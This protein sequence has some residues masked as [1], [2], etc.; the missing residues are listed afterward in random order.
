MST[1]GPARPMTF[2]AGLVPDPLPPLPDG[3]P[4]AGLPEGLA[5]NGNALE[6]RADPIQRVLVAAGEV[7]E[8]EW[9]LDQVLDAAATSDEE[10]GL[11]LD[12]APMDGALESARWA[13]DQAVAAL[14]AQLRAAADAGVPLT[15]L[16]D[17]S[18]LQIS[19]LRTALN[20]ASDT[21]ADTTTEALPAGQLRP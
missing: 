5:G 9:A 4:A 20:A 1:P 3:P 6:R 7:E 8:A 15:D 21:A 18:G 2:P 19:A 17:A 12:V 13:L 10:I 14:H 11:G 16:A